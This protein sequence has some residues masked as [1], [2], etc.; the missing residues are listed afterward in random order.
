MKRRLLLLLLTLIAAALLLVGCTESSGGPSDTDDIPTGGLVP[1]DGYVIMRS[2]VAPKDITSCSLDLRA[3]VEETCG[4]SVSIAT[5]FVKRGDPVPTDTAELV[6]GATNRRAADGLR[7][8]DWSVAREGNR[9]YLLGVTADSLGGAVSFFTEHF[10]A[11]GGMTIPDGYRYEHKAEYAVDTVRFAANEPASFGLYVSEAN[12]A[13]KHAEALALLLTEKTGRVSE[14]TSAMAKSNIIFASRSASIPSDSWGVE[15]KDGVVYVVGSTAKNMNRA[16]AYLTGLLSDAKG[17][18]VL[19]NGVLHS[20]R[21]PTKEEFLSEKR[22]VIYEE[23]PEAVRRNY[24]YD[25]SVTM[26]GKTSPLPVYNHCMQNS[27]KTRSIG[28]DLCRRFST[29]AFSA[30]TVRVDI[31][32]KSDF[33]AYL[34]GPSGKGFRH[35]FKDGVISVYLDKPDYFYIMLDNDL[36]T[37]LSVF[38][39]EP[40][41]PEDIPE[42]GEKVIIV[43]PGEWYEPE[44]GILDLT[45]PG[46]QIYVAPGGVLNARQDLRQSGESLRSRRADRPV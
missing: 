13:N 29:F 12:L 25:V 15:V 40:E 9:V 8:N 4:S 38:A 16:A 26:D 17:E 14:I 35:D 34:V 37:M 24:D 33:D 44:G 20:E 7:A 2:D 11:P 19:T 21:V 5:D 3:A 39:D 10:L 18:F 43:N 42:A 45:G 22:L 41:Y 1:L 32:V 46:W 30:G 28:G 23:F 6:V 27:V 36:N 31:Q